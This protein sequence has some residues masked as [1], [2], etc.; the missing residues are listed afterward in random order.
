M[1]KCSCLI[2][3][4]FVWLIGCVTTPEKQ[5]NVSDLI[6]K[7]HGPMTTSL[8][9]ETGHQ[10]SYR[11]TAELEIYNSELKGQIILFLSSNVRQSYPFHGQIKDN[12]LIAHWKGSR[13]MELELI[14]SRDSMRLDGKYDFIKVGGSITLEKMP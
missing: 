1:K 2:I 8:Y 4:I 9:P 11:P 14:K 13:Y 5:M 6:G 10:S 12:K 7:W 3:M